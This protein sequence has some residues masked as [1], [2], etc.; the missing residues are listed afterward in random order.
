MNR[1][2][3][4]SASALAA[5]LFAASPPACAEEARVFNIPASSLRDALN[6]FATQSDQQ[7]LFS[8]DLVAGRRT[9]GLNG[10]YA[11]SAAIDR[12]LVGTGLVWRET[13]PGVIF[14]G[15]ADDAADEVTR[16]EEV[17]VTGSLLRGTGP[18]SSPVVVLDRDALD[19]RGRGS[20]A[21]VL[22]D[23]PQNYAGSGTP[24][25][26]LGFA[27]PAGGNSALATGINL[28]GLGVGSTLTLVNGRRLAG[29]GSRG[30]FADA[31]AIPSAAVERVDVLLDG[32]SALYGSDAVAGVVNIVMRREFDG[33]ESRLRLG[34]G[35]GG[36]EEVVVSHMAGRSWDSGGAYL[37]Y[38]HQTAKGLNMLDRPYT[39]DGDLR[40]FGGTDRRGLFSSPGNIVAVAGG[41]FASQW[42]IRPGA[43]GTAQA[44]GD[45]AA[46]QANGTAL[47]SGADLMPDV[48][49]DSLYGRVRQSLGDRF[50]TSADV[51]FSHRAYG[52][53]NAPTSLGLTAGGAYD[54]G[55]GWSLDGYLGLAEERG[56]SLVF[57]VVS[58]AYLAEALGNGADNPATSYDRLRD[59]YF[60]PFG[61]GAANDRAVLDFISQ[62][63]SYKL[64]RS[65]SGSANLLA[66]G[67]VARLPGGDLDLAVGLQARRESLSSRARNL[68]STT[69]PRDVLQPDYER[70]VLAAF[71]EVRLPIVGADNARPGL[72]RLELT[73]AAR[74]EDYDDFGS[75]TNPKI[76]AVWSPARGWNLRASYGTSFPDVRRLGGDDDD[77]AAQ[78]RPA[79]SQRLS[80]RRQPRPQ[81]GDGDDLD[82]GL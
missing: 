72:E 81:A 33:Q 82:G 26:V 31:S 75:T 74:F 60:N 16:L 27:D 1:L 20:V 71:A 50:E 29:T 17:I 59:G 64:E 3:F 37:A 61:A 79:D 30:A 25:A 78:R 45:F 22:A 43:S 57:K 40:P 14:L 19:R 28:R 9:A 41:A 48:R 68:T 52:L 6:L 44:P 53:Q 39:A 51:R 7:I 42:A 18:L 70:A 58:S 11:P 47:L 13:R 32:A 46:G 2:S 63:Y 49:R 62:G 15:A 55:A 24:G 77:R 65:R 23:L 10:A 67:P 80:L 35:Q 38:E 21:E 4:V 8:S 69:T 36:S 66:S 34:A 54:L 73:A 56:E 76:G 12:L 5:C